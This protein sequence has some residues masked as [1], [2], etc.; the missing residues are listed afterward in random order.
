MATVKPFANSTEHLL[1]ELQRVDL[2]IRARVAV[3]RR[4]QSQD[5]HFRGLYV[6]EEEVDGLLE[7]PLGQPRWLDDDAR[8]L[9]DVRGKL[10]TLLQSNERRVEAS[11]AAGSSLA[12]D[13]M[14]AS[15]G[16]SAVDVDALLVALAV[17]FDLRYEKLYA[18]LQDDVTRKRPSVELILQLLGD[19]AADRL[20][21][22]PRFQADAPLLAHRLVRLVDEAAQPH[23][24]LL[25]RYVK[26]EDRIV[27]WLLRDAAA[28]QALDESIGS[29]ARL[30]QGTGDA[31]A[32]GIDARAREACAGA[33]AVTKGIAGEAPVLVLRGS[34]LH[35]DS[36]LAMAQAL[37]QAQQRSLI[38]VDVA[39]LMRAA[40]GAESLKALAELVEREARLRDAV[41]CWHGFDGMSGEDVVQRQEAV[42]A[43]VDASSVP[44]IV[45]ALGPG[46]AAAAYPRRGW[47]ACEVPA[48]DTAQRLAVWRAA[49]QGL[50][51][52]PEA[53]LEAL[54]GRFRIACSSIPA[55]AVAAGGMARLRGSEAAPITQEDLFEACRRQAC[56][57]LGELAQKMATPHRWGD[58]VL[59]AECLAQL[60]E[61]CDQVK[62]REKVIGTWGFGSRMSLGKGVAALFAGPSGTGKTMAA[63]VVARALGYDLYRIDLSTVISKY[64]GDTEKNLARIF[65][66][67][68]QAD[69]ILFFDEA[70]A[71]FGKRGEVRDSHDRYANIEVGF[72]LQRM[73]AFEG[74]AILATNLKRNMDDAFIR[75]L[76]FVVD[77]PVPDESHRLA[78]WES[79]WPEGLP[80][81][82]DV[83]LRA[84]AH[85]FEITGGLIRNAALAAAFLAAS[86]AGRP[87]PERR[88]SQAHL[89][90]AVRREYEKSGMLMSGDE[91]SAVA[92]AG[93]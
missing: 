25:A 33:W 11:R 38:E 12:L 28:S 14:R 76:H 86:D 64:I 91:W 65:D 57:R 13:R 53:D 35:E 63:G 66:E 23:P 88:M 50:P 45:L 8:W 78:I 55:A 42:A 85:R 93:R 56:R 39:R 43:I 62:H 68:E 69:V 82:D 51:L 47:V 61:L 80:R 37:A 2:L 60:T 17:D 5:E 49:L 71:L 16:L 36:A 46:D 59:P 9:K 58:L 21:A 24:P 75:R 70:D 77:F 10:E 4:R 3:L 44:A 73:E 89:L 83:D 90:H 15:F 27:D 32:L 26:V 41:T 74:I 18:Y 30:A 1:A 7:R 20:A 72:L 67:A 19:T 81:G 54:A 52:A 87:E 31:G 40:A 22:R 34:A 6:S 92:E 79:I 48:P 84:L 29:F